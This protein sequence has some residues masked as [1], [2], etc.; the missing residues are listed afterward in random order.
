MAIVFGPKI[1]IFPK[2]GQNSKFSF[3]KVPMGGGSTGLGII[4]KKQFFTASLKLTDY[5]M[6]DASAL[7]NKDFNAYFCTVY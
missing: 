6:D 1:H 7:E 2:F 3:L 5:R 4:P